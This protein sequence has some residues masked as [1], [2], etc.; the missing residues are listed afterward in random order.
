MLNAHELAW[1]HR[2]GRPLDHATRSRAE[3]WFGRDLG[4]VRI[5]DSRQAAE[6]A[7]RL[8]A[9][10]LAIRSHIFG[11]ADRLTAQTPQ[12]RGLLAHEITHV[13][14]Q[15]QPRQ[16]GGRGEGAA[17]ASSGNLRQSGL[18][19][20]PLAGPGAPGY[21]ISHQIGRDPTI[22]LAEEEAQAAEALVTSAVQDQSRGG[23][24][25][26]ASTVDADEVASRVYRI[27]QQTLVLEHERGSVR[28]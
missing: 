9:E 6:L 25:G 17:P 26:E 1:I 13:V 19:A 22:Q 18:Q 28:R 15:T 23:T 24:P 8:G 14:Q 7:G 21:W 27:M 10:A 4:D 20:K 5:H 11:P 12:G 16:L 2:S 3:S